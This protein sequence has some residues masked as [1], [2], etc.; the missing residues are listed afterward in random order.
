MIRQAHTY[1]V[2]AMSGATL[3]VIA[4]VAFVLL[5]SAQVFESFPIAAFGDGGKDTKVSDAQPVDSGSGSTPTAGGGGVAG[6]PAGKAAAGKGNGVGAGGG[7]QQGGTSPAG[8]APAGGAEGGGTGEGGSG[9]GSEGGGGG[10]SSP[11]PTQSPSSPSSGGGSS[12]GGSSGGSATSTTSGKLTETVNETVTGVDETVL[13]GA[14][15]E[16]GVTEVT[17]GLVNGLAGPES[18]VGKVVNET[19]NT[20]GGLLGGNH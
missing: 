8:G 4:I 13:G 16:S 6:V 10:G 18:P 12:S 17:E 15:K 14:L 19:V 2:S 5:V 1:L 3:I 7:S 20:V 9:G 11:A